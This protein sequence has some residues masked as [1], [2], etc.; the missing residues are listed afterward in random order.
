[1]IT[2]A[3][4]S[5][6]PRLDIVKELP[7]GVTGFLAATPQEYSE[8]FH[9]ILM[10]SDSWRKQVQVRARSHVQKFSDQEFDKNITSL[11]D[12]ILLHS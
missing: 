1:L 6:G 12:Q 2:V 10:E 5:G 9:K 7:T 4:N 3:H 8:N 11:L